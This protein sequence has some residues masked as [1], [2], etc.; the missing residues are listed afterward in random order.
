[1]PPRQSPFVWCI[2]TEP[3][4]LVH[5]IWGQLPGVIQLAGEGFD[6]PLPSPKYRPLG[7]IPASARWSNARTLP[8]AVRLGSAVMWL[9]LSHTAASPSDSFALSSLVCSLVAS[10]RLPVGPGWRPFRALVLVAALAGACPSALARSLAEEQPTGPGNKLM[11]E[12]QLCKQPEVRPGGASLPKR[13]LR[14]VVS[15]LP[16][17]T[18]SPARSLPPA[19]P[20]SW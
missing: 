11:V 15:V 14:F 16:H 4:A 8:A 13:A 19:S 1:M 12:K 9:P 6:S 10:M 7:Q 2:D 17:S 3:F 5:V 18:P 20:S